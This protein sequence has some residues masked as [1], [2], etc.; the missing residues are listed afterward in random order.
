[1]LLPNLNVA[2]NITIGQRRRL[3]GPIINWRKTY[4]DADAALKR[5]NVSLNLK[6]KVSNLL[7][8]EKQ[9]VDIA[10]ALMG[11]AKLLI[12]DEPT[13][14]LSSAE[15]KNLFHLVKEL[16]KQGI[17]II[18]ISHRLEELSEIADRV[19]VFRDGR[20]ICTHNMT[21][22]LSTEYLVEQMVGTRI[23]K[24]YPHETLVPGEVM[25]KTVNLNLGGACSNIN[26][27]AREREIVGVTG[28]I[29]S[30]MEPLAYALAGVTVADSGEIHVNGNVRS[31]LQR[32]NKRRHRIH[33]F[34]QT[35][36]GSDC[37]L[38]CLS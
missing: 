34:R 10:R 37:R 15:I 30:G 19:T 13:S 26:I 23:E 21:G 17:A 32:C 22:D 36:Y 6:E 35:R 1:M 27:E 7:A 9:I 5:L 25:L 8:S 18:Y 38:S 24:Q 3:I 29:G 11:E 20:H 31:E 33:P 12:M 4:R 16:K 14:A 28:V 2:E